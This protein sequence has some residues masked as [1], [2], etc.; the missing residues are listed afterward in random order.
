MT[1]VPVTGSFGVLAKACAADPDAG[2]ELVRLTLFEALTDL[3]EAYAPMLVDD[4]TKDARERIEAARDGLVRSHISKRLD[5]DGVSDVVLTGA[6]LTV[7]ESISKDYDEHERRDA[8]GRW[9]KTLDKVR[10][11][12]EGKGPNSLTEM[13]RPSTTRDDNTA[14]R[15]GYRHLAATGRAL[16]AV[17]GASGAGGAIGA[18][19]TL[20]GELG[21]EAEKILGP[22]LKRTAYRYRGS[23][24][25][26]SV[27]VQQSAAELSRVMQAVGDGKVNTLKGDDAAAF[28]AYNEAP[29]QSGRPGAGSR[30]SNDPAVSVAQYWGKHAQGM[31]GDQLRLAA[32]SDYLT[33]Q[34]KTKIPDLGSARL[35][36]AAGKMPPSVGY[37]VDADGDVVSEAQGF[38][39]DHY[40]PFD[41]ANLRRLSGGAYVRTRAV[42]G[43]T[44]EDIYTALAT[45]TRQLQVASRSGIFTV[46]FDPDLRGGRRYS[47]KTRQMVDRYAKLLEQINSGDHMEVPFSP[48]EEREMRTA[49]VRR[50][51]DDP[52]RQKELLAEEKKK[53]LTSLTISTDDELEQQ[54]HE[55]VTAQFREAGR[56]GASYSRQQMG[57]AVE[58]RV[59]EL[60]SER[61]ATDARAYA[62]NGTGYEAALKALQTEFPYSIRKATYTPWNRFLAERG[63][64]TEDK[65]TGGNAKDLGY[66]P[67][68]GVTPRAAGGQKRTAAAAAGTAATVAA[69][70]AAKPATATQVATAQATPAATTTPSPQ[71]IATSPLVNDLGVA[72]QRSLGAVNRVSNQ[73]PAAEN[74]TEALSE[75]AGGYGKWLLGAHPD[76]RELATWL[77]TKAD[78]RHITKL[79]GDLAWQDRQIDAYDDGEDIRAE[80]PEIGKAQGLLGEAAIVREPYAPTGD[81]DPVL[82]IASRP[83]AF[84]DTTLGF[85]SLAPYKAYLEANPEVAKDFASIKAM[86]DEQIATQLNDDITRYARLKA[87]GEKG[88]EA[89]I[90]TPSGVNPRDASEAIAIAQDGDK[91]PDY[92]A[93]ANLQKAW[94]VLRGAQVAAALGGMRA[95][96][97]GAPASDADPKDPKPFGKVAPRLTVHRLGSP[98]SQALARTAAY[99]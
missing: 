48:E 84:P 89:G 41:L 52:A 12:T 94:S 17:T 18:T 21:P 7:L 57:Q 30:R 9:T 82:A 4:I 34:L 91:H 70:S 45:N 75:P 11:F 53:R 56:R 86:P 28:R 49:V 80:Y 36:L 54:A 85:T 61:Q 95:E 26:P 3:T 76:P 81:G 72:L 46:E 83:Q 19:A 6:Y 92:V 97:L 71:E 93:I 33:D 98:L 55:E 69:A 78:P 40:L 20:V 32:T 99:R 23:E 96:A 37:I 24:Q 13:T 39:G 35:S 15:R 50:A 65:P 73:L 5:G 64:A 74:E 77:L 63:L 58:D 66:T 68:N 62:L 51:P 16:T 60:Q 44:D 43:P 22:G 27:E 79:Q 25:K 87:W 67:R 88:A 10:T 8:R 2:A 47:D 90:D 42:G 29:S 31:T 14:D 38:N 59:R 1:L